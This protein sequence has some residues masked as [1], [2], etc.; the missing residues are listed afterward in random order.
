MTSD[1]PKP[2]NKGGRPRKQGPKAPPAPVGRPKNTPEKTAQLRQSVRSE[3][4]TPN[5][6]PVAGLDAG[7]PD[8]YLPDPPGKKGTTKYKAWAME[9]FL[10]LLRHGYNYSQA[11]VRIGY[12][13]KWWSLMSKREP[14]WAEEARE[15]RTSDNLQDWTYPDLTHMPFEE[16]VRE[17]MGID[18]VEHQK[19]IA[20]SL[21][22]P[23][24][25][26]V[27]ILGFPESG[28]STLVSLWYVL[29]RLAQNP[30]A[31]IAIVSKSSNKA[32]DLLNRV[33]RYLTEDHLYDDS[34][35]NL[36]ADFNGWKSP[37][38]EAEWSQ[39]AIFVRH[40]KS[41][42]R[43]PSVQA[44]GIQK[45]IYGSRLDYL[46]LDDALILDNQ[47]SELQRDRIDQWFTNEARS[48][49]QRG[50][51]VV[52]GTRLFPMDLYGQWKKSWTSHHLFRGVYI[53]AIQQEYGENE[54]V[55]WPEYWTLDGY[56][57]TEEYGGETIVTGHQPGMRDIRQEITARDPA[58]WRM[59]YQQEDVEET[60][61]IFRQ[62]HINAAIELG[63]DRRLGQV[64]DHEILILGVDPATTG[65]AASV[66]IALDPTTRVRTVVDI[67]VG[68]KLG[69]NGIRN[70]LM[71]RFWDKYKDHRV[72]Y[73]VIEINFAPT[74]MGDIDFM[75]RAES[76]GTQ[77]VEHQ[78]TGRG[79]RRGS[80]W[81][82]E[83][84][85]G[86]LVSL[87]GGGLI[88]F[89]NAGADD[90]KRL[91]PLIDDMLVFPWAAA[92]D[93]LVALWVANG[94]TSFARRDKVNQSQMR[95]RRGV[96]DVISRRLRYANPQ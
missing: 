11:C 33:K 72:Q 8:V 87:F 39:D 76:A 54:Q 4:W 32:Q 42:E 78:T 51:T 24:G 70:E 64:Y 44:L 12:T 20:K 84:G 52:N 15:I 35:R 71:Y 3:L 59:V 46:I 56:D 86:A 45:Q 73:T 36:I 7:L 65:R 92:Q 94:E 40:R 95:Q 17:Y 13:D 9:C 68:D 16:F 29:Y 2:E 88:S 79:H 66:L 22:D 62:E 90:L 67:F 93:A 69:S 21:E 27:L 5:L 31:R 55:T 74:L 58:R 96:P 89:P 10:E 48:R 49:A 6:R 63:A 57:I 30:D 50:Q 41:G 19:D 37:H 77:I 60:E 18:L 75:D 34:P 80:K 38:G 23:M 25:K 1:D 81:D 14:E 53:P 61:N 91:Q 85:I 28:K 43:D 82:E 83:Y 26:L 47:T